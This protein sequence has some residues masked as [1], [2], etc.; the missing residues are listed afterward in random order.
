MRKINLLLIGILLFSNYSAYANQS[1]KNFYLKL[2]IVTANN[3]ATIKDKNNDMTSFVKQTS[4]ISPGIGIGGGYHF[5]NNFRMDLIAE[6]YTFNFNNSLSEFHTFS[7]DEGTFTGTKIIKR[8]GIGSSLMLNG[9]A[10][11][12]TNETYQLFVGAG[13]GM[14]RLKE[15]MSSLISGNLLN[16]EGQLFA[17]PLV[18]EN[19]SSKTST[20]PSYCLLFG[21]NTKVNEQINLEFTYKWQNYG[22]TKYSHNSPIRNNIYKGSSI[23][24][25]LG[26]DL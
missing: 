25:S 23:S 16:N 1:D 18:I 20:N 4:Q 21:I 11:I 24:V 17:F 15:R 19:H 6:S 12:L 13:V 9:Y 5:D 22:K 14:V 8:K 3:L 7:E 2:I 10:N 26:V